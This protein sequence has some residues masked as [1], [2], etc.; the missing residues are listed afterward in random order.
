MRSNEFLHSW[1]LFVVIFFSLVFLF[2]NPS[3][4]LNIILVTVLIVM[5]IKNGLPGF[6]FLKLFIYALFF[7]FGI[8]VLNVFHP[9]V[10]LKNGEIYQI[11]NFTLY[12]LAI[13]RGVQTFI[14]LFFILFTLTLKGF[15]FVAFVRWI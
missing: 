13:E 9:A 7:S 11:L 12:K 1:Y 2:F 5:C 10:A 4:F 8:F 3:I 14:K 15:A 6:V